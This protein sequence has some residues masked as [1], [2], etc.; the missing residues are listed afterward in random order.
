M[1]AGTPAAVQFP[2][3]L[4]MVLLDLD[5]T[6]VDSAPDIADSANLML[7]DLGR[8][9]HPQETVAR[10]IG[11]GVSRLVKRALTGEMG[12]EPDGVLYERAIA[13]F[14]VHYA[15]RLAAKTRPFPGVVEGLQR[16]QSMGFALTCIT[17]KAQAFTLPLLE[18]L[19]LA[20]YFKL[21]VSGD[22]L[23]KK[24]P[25]PLPLLHACR[26][27]GIEP[28][29]AV[30][31]GDSANDVKAARAAGMPVICVRYGYNHGRDI[32]EH[33]PDAVID[34]LAELPGYLKLDA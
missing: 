28:A 34:S 6:L 29:R 26:H 27:L 17:N 24:K 5:G 16:L 22:T 32:R 15:D 18:R 30:F 13:R 10:W 1:P 4:K 3:A 8:P 12:A 31:V 20:R 2:L 14:Y 11:D 23:A 25:D 21:T 9:A 7:A 33:D 19:D